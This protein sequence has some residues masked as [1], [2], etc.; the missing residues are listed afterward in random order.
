MSYRKKYYPEF[1]DPASIEE[2]YSPPEIGSIWHH[3]LNDEDSELNN[4]FASFLWDNL[5]DASN[6][7]DALYDE[8]ENGEVLK[9][10]YDELRKIFESYFEELEKICANEVF[11]YSPSTLDALTWE[12]DSS[13]KIAIYYCYGLYCIDRALRAYFLDQKEF[14]SQAFAFGSSAISSALS[15]KL[16]AIQEAYVLKSNSS[17][18]GKAKAARYKPLKELAKT[19]VE[20]GNYKSRRN[21]ANIIAPKILEAGLKLNPPVR[22]SEHQAEL[23]I[24]LWLKEMGLPLKI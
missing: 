11:N 15:M 2:P 22:L 5:Q 9:K 17:K 8:S 19:L 20:T 6:D 7:I 13:K 14:S 10:S 16:L 18:A 4:E 24:A 12:F 1:F 21:A 3:F 23:T